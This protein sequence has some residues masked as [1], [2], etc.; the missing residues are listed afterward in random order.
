[1]VNKK[2]R[3]L[4]AVLAMAF[5]L[6]VAGCSSDKNKPLSMPTDSSEMEGSN[7]RTVVAQL[8]DAGFKNV[9][10]IKN[11]DLIAG[12]L[13]KDGDVETISINGETDLEKGDRFSK[14]AKVKVTY[15]TFSK[16]SESSS[17]RSSSTKKTPSTSSSDN[18]SSS[19]AMSTAKTSSSSTAKLAYA[20]TSRREKNEIFLTGSNTL[21]G[22]DGEVVVVEIA[23]DDSGI[24]PGTYSV[25]WMPGLLHGSDPDYAYGFVSINGDTANGYG[26]N[27]DEPET[28]TFKAGDSV[29]FKFFG[30]GDSDRIF[31][32]QQ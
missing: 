3:L 31:L 17:G 10:T 2:G 7:Y 13:H 4:L 24:K 25:K 22:H 32:N 16:K 1:M 18:S 21:I 9:K 28:I 20:L 27:V 12:L 29:T 30:Q 26:L 19:S 14:D 15:H 11:P 23:T 8:K 6:L 5:V